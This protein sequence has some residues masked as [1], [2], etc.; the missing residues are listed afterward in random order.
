MDI[1]DS[2]VR[3]M[4]NKWDKICEASGGTNCTAVTETQLGDYTK[5]EVLYPQGYQTY[6]KG[7][8]DKI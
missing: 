1:L 5:A 4:R 2:D 7:W 8:P 3:C 6:R